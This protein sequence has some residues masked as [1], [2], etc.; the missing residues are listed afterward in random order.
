MN[1]KSGVVSRNRYGDD[2]LHFPV[3][4]E[5][6]APREQI[7]R[8]AEIPADCERIERDREPVDGVPGL[9]REELL[10]R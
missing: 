8:Q 10:C 4:K 5:E 7:E 9:G 6:P 1:G 2:A 3:E